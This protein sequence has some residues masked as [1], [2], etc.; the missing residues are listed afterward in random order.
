M[1]RKLTPT[2]SSDRPFTIFNVWHS[3][4]SF[5]GEIHLIQLLFRI[6]LI[7]KSTWYN[8]WTTWLIK[9][10]YFHSVNID[11][12]Y[13]RRRRRSPFPSPFSS[14]LST[15]YRCRW[16]TVFPFFSHRRCRSLFPP[17]P[18]ILND[19]RSLLHFPTT[20]ITVVVGSPSVPPRTVVR[21][22]FVS[23]PSLLLL[24]SQSVVSSSLLHHDRAVVRC[25][26]VGSPSLLLLQPLSVP[27]PSRLHHGRSVGSPSPLFL[28]SP[29]V[30]RRTRSVLRLRLLYPVP[31][32]LLY[33]VPNTKF[34]P[35]APGSGSEHVAC[36]RFRTLLNTKR[37]PTACTR[38]RLV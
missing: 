1:N 6:K 24:P 3:F 13:R 29:Y 8:Y 37:P 9:P 31:A 38:F 25:E 11:L 5:I 7:H 12:L 26:F 18:T 17:L 10:H 15:A 19:S 20:S 28:S 30:L 2:R 27:L 23:F 32:R 4:R 34:P 35:P 16:F 36:T 22:R 21:R 14:Y 33:P